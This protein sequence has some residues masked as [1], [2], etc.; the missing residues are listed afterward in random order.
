MNAHEK[1]AQPTHGV[2][3]RSGFAAL[4]TALVSAM[5]WRLLLLWILAT[6]LPTWLAT[7]PLGSALQAQFGNSIHAGDIAA[8]RD[9]PLLI[10]GMMKV[11]EQASPIMAATVT[12]SIVML[13]LSPWLTGMIVASLRARRRLGFGELIHGG[14]G[15][16]WRMLRMLVWSLIPLGIAIGIGAAAMGAADKATE[17]AILSSDVQATTRIALWLAVIVFMIAHA[18]V[19]AGRGWLGADSSLRSVIRAWWR[20]LKLLLRRPIATLGVYLGSIIVGFGLALLLSWLRLNVDGVG[21]TALVLS[22]L[23][24]QAMVAALAWG[25]IV[26]LHGLSDLAGNALARQV[27]RQPVARTQPV[28]APVEPAAAT[29]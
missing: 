24:T 25:K 22:F 2:A 11:G 23:V 28:A 6:L 7:A 29:T 20:G 16:Y 26:R 17:D 14:L 10:Q 4:M 27:V 18:S 9:L 8:G 21:M 1:H 15:E 5:Q 12:A 3:R 19:E 13:L